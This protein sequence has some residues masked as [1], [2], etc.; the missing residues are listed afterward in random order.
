MNARNA[1][2]GCAS[3]KRSLRPGCL[4]K[5]LTY[6]EGLEFALF[7]RKLN[8]GLNVSSSASRNNGSWDSCSS[9]LS[10]QQLQHPV[11][12]LAQ[13]L[14][15][16]LIRCFAINRSRAQWT[17][18]VPVTWTNHECL[19]EQMCKCSMLPWPTFKA[20]MTA[21]GCASA[22]SRLLSTAKHLIQV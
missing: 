3:S 17:T 13:Q 12:D 19:I 20:R 7:R 22:A 9:K 16:E 14:P 8:W 1:Q 11:G 5:A 10:L 21:V 4:A 6:K 2:T 15:W 18:P